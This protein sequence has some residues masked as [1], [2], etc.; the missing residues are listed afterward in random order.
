MNRMMSTDTLASQ[1]E[2]FSAD[3]LPEVNWE[4]YQEAGILTPLER[5]R[6]EA[7]SAQKRDV[8]QI[9]DIVKQTGTIEYIYLFIKLLNGVHK[10][11]ALINIL[12]LIDLLFENCPELCQQFHDVDQND[13]SNQNNPFTPFLSLFIK[14]DIF[15]MEKAFNC[16]S[17]LFEL[18]V[19]NE[20]RTSLWNAPEDQEMY[21]QLQQLER[22]NR[23]RSTQYRYQSQLESFI[24]GI[25]NQLKSSGDDVRK[26]R[27]CVKALMRLLKRNDCRAVL[28]K[29]K[30]IAPL[31][32][33]LRVH[34]NNVQILYEVS[35]CLWMLTFHENAVSF[36]QN[37]SLVPK[38]H[39]VL[40]CAQKEKV[41]RVI[42]FIFKNLM[43]YPKFV[44][45]M[46]NVSVP[47]TL[48]NLQKRS[49]E[50]KDI[51]EELKS[52][53]ENLDAHI[54]EISSFDDYRQEVLSG[55]LEWTPVHSSEKFWKENMDKM[56]QNNFYILRELIKLLDDESNTDNLAIGCHD[57]G[58]FV[59]YHNRGKRVVTDL[60]AKAR[61]LQLMEHP[62]DEV[63]KYA[64]ECCQK[65]MIKNY[66]LIR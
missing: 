53:S 45:A 14:N 60:G 40:K 30:G 49:F 35:A 61:I 41:I 52:L 2:E 19:D 43:K 64:L 23:T 59:R 38:L 36:F 26:S 33:L 57:I 63:K 22:N 17:R 37:E 7:I 55:H 50:D 46:V 9:I 29:V 18:D 44:T 25:S 15:I 10:N 3:D 4:S 65:I 12:Y 28:N 16:L 47:K 1:A 54:D 24:E 62:N 32:N 11:E 56:E 27:M 66:D 21:R 48:L 13:N 8:K 42:L 31:V 5:Q 34:R 51:T 39:D 6:I 58:E 20:S